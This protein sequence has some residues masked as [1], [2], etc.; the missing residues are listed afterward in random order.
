L[1]LL[2]NEGFNLRANV[3][4]KQLW[5]KGIFAGKHSQ[6]DAFLLVRDDSAPEIVPETPCVSD[7]VGIMDRLRNGRV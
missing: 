6:N 2:A 1:V 7:V 4:A 5:G 3:K